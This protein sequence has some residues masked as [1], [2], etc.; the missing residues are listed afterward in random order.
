MALGD[1]MG[2]DDSEMLGGWKGWQKSAIQENPNAPMTRGSILQSMVL[3]K[4]TE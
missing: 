4:W 3:L 2:V 1:I